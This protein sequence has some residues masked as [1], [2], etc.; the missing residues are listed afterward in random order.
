MIKKQYNYVFTGQ[1]DQVYDFDLSFDFLWYAPI[2][3]Q[4]GK[5]STASMDGGVLLDQKSNPDLEIKDAVTKAS[6]GKHK[7]KYFI[8]F[9]CCFT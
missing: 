6:K 2:P 9:F 5:H 3:R 4:V 8:C 7:A 1:N